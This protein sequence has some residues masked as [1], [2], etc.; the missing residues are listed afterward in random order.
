MRR[1]ATAVAILLQ[2]TG[3][4]DCHLDITESLEEKECRIPLGPRTWSSPHAASSWRQDRES[5]CGMS[6]E[7]EQDL[8]KEAA[9]EHIDANGYCAANLHRAESHSLEE[10][11]HRTKVESVLRRFWRDSGFVVSHDEALLVARAGDKNLDDRPWPTVGGPST[12]GEISPLGVRQIGRAF[13]LDTL[14]ISAERAVFMDLGCGVGKM[15][16]QAYLEWPQVVQAVGIELS[17][18][19]LRIAKSAKERLLATPAT[20]SDHDE[21]NDTSLLH[22]LRM[23]VLS[24]PVPDDSEGIETNIKTDVSGSI[25]P[26]VP[27]EEVQLIEGD[28]FQVDISKATHIY[29]SSLCFD[30]EMLIRLA[31]KLETEAPRLRAIAALRAFPNGV[32]GFVERRLVEAEMTWSKRFL[33]GSHVHLYERGSEHVRPEQQRSLWE[34]PSEAEEPKEPRREEEHSDAWHIGMLE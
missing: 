1:L 13:H 23:E 5:L 31:L 7:D 4:F 32:S 17:P 26:P 20:Y 11:A 28:I 25:M 3:S 6:S 21:R 12:Y 34:K 33:G 16:V 10:A 30:N 24:L 8:D 9:M 29:V 18:T 15:V 14:N 2:R 22:C 27:S 19:R